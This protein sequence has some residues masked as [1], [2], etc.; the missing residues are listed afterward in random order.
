MSL[1]FWVGFAALCVFLFPRPF[2]FLN[3]ECA[4]PWRGRMTLSRGSTISTAYTVF[5]VRPHGQRS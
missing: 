2:F 4:Y 1:L 3:G 5:P